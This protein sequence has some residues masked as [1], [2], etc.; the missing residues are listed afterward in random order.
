MK[1][2]YAVQNGNNF[3]WDW[4]S[5]NYN[6]AVEMANDLVNDPEYDDQEIRIAIIDVDDNFC[7]DEITIRE[8]DR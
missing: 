7:D 3:D 5:E 1:K 4:G 6:K 2:F 8:G